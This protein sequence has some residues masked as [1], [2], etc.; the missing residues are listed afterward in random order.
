MEMPAVP[1]TPEEMHSLREAAKFPY[2]CRICKAKLNA[3]S[4]Y[5]IGT[6]HG[7]G[8]HRKVAAAPPKE[9]G[10][11]RAAVIYCAAC[12]DQQVRVLDDKAPRKLMSNQ[13]NGDP[14]SIPPKLLGNK[15][16]LK[17]LR[18]KKAAELEA[19]NA[20]PVW[21]MVEPGIFRA[22]GNMKIQKVNEKAWRVLVGK[23]NIVV[24]G[25][26]QA[27]EVAAELRRG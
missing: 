11:L 19:K 23:A 7:G 22:N 12:A 27:F 8:E 3:Q 6:K 25:L 16:L 26:Q 14:V 15:E 20:P 17:Q 1:H 10:R 9:E 18:Q 4:I 21:E 5:R 13:M 24:A 2:E